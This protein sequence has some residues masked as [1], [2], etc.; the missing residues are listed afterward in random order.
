MTDT[1]DSRDGARQI[2][3]SDAEV[4]QLLQRTSQQYEQSIRLADLAD[5]S[6]LPAAGQPRYAWDNPVG[7][8]VTGSSHAKLV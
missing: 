5:L 8:V 2:R 6:D 1:Q 3:P 4:A 7:L